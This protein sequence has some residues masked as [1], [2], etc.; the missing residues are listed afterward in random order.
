MV[1]VAPLL[2]HGYVPTSLVQWPCV[3]LSARRGASKVVTLPSQDI[4]G[5]GQRAGHLT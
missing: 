1:D 4:S 2:L 3:A 5:V